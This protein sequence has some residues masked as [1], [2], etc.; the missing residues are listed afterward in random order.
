MVGTCMRGQVVKCSAD[1]GAGIIKPFLHCAAAVNSCEGE[2]LDVKPTDR[3]VFFLKD[4]QMKCVK[5]SFYTETQKR[6]DAVIPIIHT[7]TEVSFMLGQHAFSE[8]D[9]IMGARQGIQAKKITINGTSRDTSS[10]CMSN[11]EW[12]KWREEQRQL[13]KLLQ[14]RGQTDACT[15]HCVGLDLLSVMPIDF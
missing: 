8:R 4:V 13:E 15:P 12:L 14:T 6:S 9:L 3:I 10:H 5:Q 2:L 7:G 1:L 11:L